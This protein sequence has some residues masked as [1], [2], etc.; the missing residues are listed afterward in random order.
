MKH[1]FI[2]VLVFIL[3]AGIALAENL[4]TDTQKEDNNNKTTPNSSGYK[5]SPKLSYKSKKTDEKDDALKNMKPM[6]NQMLDNGSNG[7]TGPV[8]PNGGTYSF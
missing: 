6:L 8:M 1:C 4:P 3:S 7:S 2:A 5:T